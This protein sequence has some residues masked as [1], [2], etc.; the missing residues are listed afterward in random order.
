M[1]GSHPFRGDGATRGLVAPIEEYDHGQGCSIT[2]GSVYRGHALP[3][4]AG[5]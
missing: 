5:C 3:D 2:G 1:E 4:V